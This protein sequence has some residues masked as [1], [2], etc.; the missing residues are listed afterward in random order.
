MYLQWRNVV[1]LFKINGI[2]AMDPH[3]HTFARTGESDLKASNSLNSAL[4][5]G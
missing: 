5:G 1:F 4:G 2:F 3:G